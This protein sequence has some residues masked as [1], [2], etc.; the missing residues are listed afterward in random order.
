MTVNAFLTAKQI[1]SLTVPLLVRS[2][3]LPNTVSMIPGGEYSGPNGGTISVRTRAVMAA[4][5]QTTARTQ[6]V[7]D[8]LTE[9]GVDVAVTHY[10]NANK[11]ADEDLTLKLIDFGAQVLAPMIDGIAV[12]V[13]GNL[14]ASMNG[15]TAAATQFAF[16]PTQADT[17]ARLLEARKALTVANVPAGD[18]YLAVSPDVTNRILSIPDFTRVDAAGND[19]ALRDATVGRLFGFTVVESNALTAGSAVA[20]HRSAF[21]FANFTPQPTGSGPGVDLAVASSQ[22]ITMRT[23]LQWLPDFLSMGVVIQ[24]FGGSGVIDATRAYR[25]TAATS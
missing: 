13:E 22:G 6:I 15:V 2:I 9:A 11:V 24:A 14:A 17:I 19:T 12:A 16:V 25:I 20:Y 7:W 1:S 21:A 18:R 8:D 3:V 10:Y 4:R 5:T 23:A